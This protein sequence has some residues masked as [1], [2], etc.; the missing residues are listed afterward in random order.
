MR[1]ENEDQNTTLAKY[2]PSSPFHAAHLGIVW[3][4]DCGSRRSVPS[5][6]PMGRVLSTPFYS[7][8]QLMPRELSDQ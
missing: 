2:L 7:S 5:G 1:C 8:D 4:S 3:Q 6:R